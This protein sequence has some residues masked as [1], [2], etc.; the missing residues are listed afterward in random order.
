MHVHNNINYCENKEARFTAENEV[1][2]FNT[3]VDNIKTKLDNDLAKFT[4]SLKNNKEATN[5]EAD[6]CI[7][8]T[9]VI[10]CL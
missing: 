7:F 5:T 9:D 4:A 3:K 6:K 10:A 8:E 1:A 2:K